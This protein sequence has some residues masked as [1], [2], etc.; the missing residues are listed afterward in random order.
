[1]QNHAEALTLLRCIKNMVFGIGLMVFAIGLLAFGYVWAQNTMIFAVIFYGGAPLFLMG[2]IWWWVT[3][4]PSS[5]E[6]TPQ[7]AP[8]PSDSVNL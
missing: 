8:P 6:S 3:R 7:D 5:P 4:R 1:M 2:A